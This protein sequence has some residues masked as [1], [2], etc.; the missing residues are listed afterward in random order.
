MFHNDGSYLIV[1]LNGNQCSIWSNSDFDFEMRNPKNKPQPLSW[2]KLLT[3]HVSSL[4]LID[5]SSYWPVTV[6]LQWHWPQKPPNQSLLLSWRT[7]LSKLHSM[8]HSNI[9][10]RAKAAMQVFVSFYMLYVDFLIR[11]ELQSGII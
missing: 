3:Y 6:F 1:L 2:Y 10:T 9:L 11:T 5:N 8:V 4:Q 7:L